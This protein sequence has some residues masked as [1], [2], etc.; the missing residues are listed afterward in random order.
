M[1]RG[2]RALRRPVVAKDFEETSFAMD[3]SIVRPLIK[4]MLDSRDLMPETREELAEYLAELDKG[5]LH[6]DDVAYVYGLARRLGYSEGGVPADPYAA[7]AMGDSL[8]EEFPG[9]DD[10][11]GDSETAAAV[12]AE[13]AL[14]SVEQAQALVAR[15]RQTG[16]GG[17]GADAATLDEI[18]KALGDAAEALK[19]RD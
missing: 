15:L 2:G 17:A 3:V 13:I 16:A 9:G 5:E 19:P 12:R 4:K 14:R 11:D 10:G 8:G 1:V 18:E 7:E 6:P